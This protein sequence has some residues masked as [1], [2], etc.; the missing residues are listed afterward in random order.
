MSFPARTS[1]SDADGS[2]LDA[3]L[4]AIEAATVDVMPIAN[5]DPLG[6]RRT[7][8]VRSLGNRTGERMLCG[9]WLE[10]N[11]SRSGSAGPP[12]FARLRLALRF[13]RST[14]VVEERE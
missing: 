14:Q 9:T 3:V 10:F 12:A 13:A 7:R 1:S 2:D 6:R 11:G 4:V 5:A 8:V